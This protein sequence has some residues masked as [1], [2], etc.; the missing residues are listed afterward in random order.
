MGLEE[1][2]DR[3]P[4]F[5]A[6]HARG[7]GAAAPVGCGT[8]IAPR[9]VLTCAHV[10]EAALGPGATPGEHDIV[11]VSFPF[12]DPRPIDSTVVP[13]SWHPADSGTRL[14]DVAVLMLKK[15]PP[16]GAEPVRVRPP[17]RRDGPQFRTWGYPSGY[18]D[19]IPAVGTLAGSSGPLG[20]WVL[21]AGGVT[22]GYR[23]KRGFSGAPVWVPEEGAV[24]G[25]VVQEDKKQP[26]AK[27]G[28]MLPVDT[29]ALY[30]SGIKAHVPSPLQ[31]DPDYRSHWWPR[32]RGMEP[33]SSGGG[34]YFA[35]RQRAVM[36]LLQA[37]QGT[38]PRFKSTVLC[39][40]PGS[41][42]SSLLAFLATL[43]DDRARE[44]VPAE[45][46]SRYGDDFPSGAVDAAIL[47]RG[48]T[49]LDVATKIAQRIGLEPPRE[50]I[51][52]E[53]SAA[54]DRRLRLILDGIDEPE[55]GAHALLRELIIPLATRENVQI[56]T[57]ARPPLASEFPSDL[58]DPID[59][60]DDTPNSGYLE[61]EDI[62]QYVHDVLVLRHDPNGDTAY[63]G[64]DK[65]ARKIAHAVAKNAAPS[66]LVAQL[67]AQALVR[68]RKIVDH[69]SP[70]W[71]KR[72][73]ASVA[74]AMDRYLKT[75]GDDREHIENLL[76]AP[77][78]T[79]PDGLSHDDLWVKIANRL[80]QT[81]RYTLSELTRVLLRAAFLL[82]PLHPEPGPRA[83]E[84]RIFHAALAQYLRD[85]GRRPVL[86]TGQAAHA[87]I[88]E[89]F[90]LAVSEGNWTRLVWEQAPAL[91][92]SSIAT[93]AARGGVL[94]K[95]LTKHRFL[96]LVERQQMQA[97]LNIGLPQDVDGLRPVYN[98]AAPCLDALTPHE[99]VVAL[100]LA[101][102][103]GES[104]KGAI[105]A[106]MPQRDAVIE[107]RVE[108]EVLPDFYFPVRGARELAVED[109]SNDIAIAFR[110]DSG[111][112]VLWLTRAGSARTIPE[113]ESE[114]I[115]LHES[116]LAFVRTRNTILL[117]EWGES[118][119]AVDI[120]TGPEI[121][122]T[123]SQ[124]HNTRGPLHGRLIATDDR[125]LVVEAQLN[126]TLWVREAGAAPLWRSKGS[127]E[128][129]LSIEPTPAQRAGSAAVKLFDEVTSSLVVPF[130][131][132]PTLALVTR[133]GDLWWLT[134]DGMQ[135]KA[136]RL[137]FRART[138]YPVMAAAT[139]DGGLLA[140]L[141]H[142]GRFALLGGEGEQVHPPMR[143]AVTRRDIVDEAAIILHDGRPSLLVRTRGR[144][145]VV[146]SVPTGE[147]TFTNESLHATHVSA[148][149]VRDRDYVV[150]STDDDVRLWSSERFF[151]L[152]D[153]SLG[154]VSL[155]VAGVA[156]RAWLIIRKG[157]SRLLVSRASNDPLQAIDLPGVSPEF[158]ALGHHHN[159]EF[160]IVCTDLFRGTTFAIP[161]EDDSQR[162]TL[163]G[164]EDRWP[165]EEGAF[166]LESLACTAD[167]DNQ[168]VLPRFLGHVFNT[169]LYRDARRVVLDPSARHLISHH[170]GR[171]DLTIVDSS[172]PSIDR[173]ADAPR[174]V[175]ACCSI[176]H[177]VFL[178][179]TENDHVMVRSSA[180]VTAWQVATLSGY[181]RNI[182]LGARDG[183][184]F[185]AVA[186]GSSL[187]LG[188]ISSDGPRRV[189]RF[190]VDARSL[191]FNA[192]GFLFIGTRFGVIALDPARA[193][194]Q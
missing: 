74:A 83:N 176:E 6:I 152:K 71:S 33:G 179:Y 166:R 84:Y 181:L 191:A 78:F 42:K 52:F 172:Q 183:N 130:A 111:R 135:V 139:Y 102:Y 133:T 94:T 2:G 57:A 164:Q 175:H 72:F 178:A 70:N 54:G 90:E 153:S 108:G 29:V 142:D 174:F 95:T 61:L 105:A 73:P 169:N 158:L 59:L 53:S 46:L 81:E 124:V 87:V 31:L 106:L 50:P 165:F 13:E 97:A 157:G 36:A 55:S 66:F 60:D 17:D 25:I 5:V 115:G 168:L 114:G 119:R 11:S 186:D 20:Q 149:Q 49:P 190:P 109:Y 146:Q 56:I 194:D 121:P 12:V 68:E 4:Y 173:C 150:A 28:A 113:M 188:L 156:T 24:L 82:S 184:V 123:P 8:L 148:L 27:I 192:D 79:Y 144:Q 10:V 22:G 77:A 45:V 182:S 23:V 15:D 145:I 35:G 126:H 37:V 101:A 26:D 125:A 189:R 16:R 62:S 110:D 96:H 64:Q 177:T 99:R 187:Q 127:I 171:D 19:P 30:W 75:F 107:A 63:R 47:A 120:G 89:V 18:P 122:H 193:L 163:L 131:D 51:D 112:V 159:E 104:D 67:V 154:P 160:I 85:A 48:L 136:M 180:Q 100:A 167:A 32:A 129:G 185:L 138:P 65:V 14:G 137:G 76:A 162:L 86:P 132:R 116:G 41:G 40:G 80:A 143:H 1:L 103:D 44:G 141:L 69:T 88:T 170:E 140:V 134:L 21:L 147:V 128:T 39:G 118:V 92:R 98:Y 161:L 43:C 34:W 151:R 7:E 91:V 93:H 9:L 38:G 117:S 3:P 155:I 58:F